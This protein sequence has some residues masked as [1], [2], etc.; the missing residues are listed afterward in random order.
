M[1]ISVLIC[2]RNRAASLRETLEAVLDQIPAPHFDY[3]MVIVDNGSTDTT[4]QV[5]AEFVATLPSPHHGRIRYC[6][7]TEPG[8]SRARNM[9]LQV[10]TGDIIVF[11][12]DDIWPES[13]WLQEIYKEFAAD[14]DLHLL[15]GRVLLAHQN[16]Q[17]VGILTG[18]QPATLTTPEAGACLIG[19]NIAIRR[20]VF[21]TV[22]NFDVRLG[23]G[24][25]FS[26]AE[27]VEFFYRSIK[28]GFKLKYAPN[29]T[30]YHNHDRVS[31]E[32]AC[33]LE[34]N[35]GKGEVAYLMKQIWSGDFYACK[36]AYWSL[37]GM[38]RK[39]F[40]LAAVSDEV[41][42]RTRAH[43]RGFIVGFFPALV[44]MR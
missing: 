21:D 34:F 39:A 38:I 15:G 19:A 29:V 31:H 13:T 20:A 25:F 22:G 26:G 42:A 7:A 8:L 40:G 32:Q 14:A 1:K 41:V 12:D 17:P 6:F 37:Y 44:R 4:R 2:T 24:Q 23:A 9:G 43:M 30:V 5:I 35:Y 10:A 16:L 11:T 18:D 33:N 27:D 28:A 3:E 36:V